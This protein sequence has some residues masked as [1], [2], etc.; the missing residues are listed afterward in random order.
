MPDYDGET[1]RCSD[2]ITTFSDPSIPR[3]QFDPIHGNL[4]YMTMLQSVV[5]K[6]LDMIII[7]MD[8]LREFF[9]A[10]KD[11]GFIER[12]RM[13]TQRYIKLF[14]SVIDSNLPLPSEQI[15]EDK[16]TTF[17]IVMQQRRFNTQQSRQ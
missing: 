9:N 3:E 17:D 6:K 11:Q 4:K 8:Y 10:N 7:E 13:N 16:L 2:F 1:K 14:S 15:D 5:N 12:V